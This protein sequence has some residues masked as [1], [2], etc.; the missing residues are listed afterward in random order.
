V[1]RAGLNSAII[2]GVLI[3]KRAMRAC[4]VVIVGMMVGAAL[5]SVGGAFASIATKAGGAT[6]TVWPTIA[7]D[8]AHTGRSQFNTSANPGAQKWKLGT[9][10]IVSSPAVGA[11]GTIY[12]GS[13]DFNLYAVAPDGSRK[14]AF[15]TTSAV[16]SPSIGNDGTIYVSDDANL[17][18]VTPNGTKKWAFPTRVGVPSL[19]A[20]RP[21]ASSTGG[22]VA[23]P[24]ISAEGTVYVTTGE[25]LYAV[26]PDGALNWKLAISY[27]ARSSPAIGPDGVIYVGSGDGNLYAINPDG[28]KRW[29]FET[30][31]FVDSSPAIGTDGTI[32]VATGYPDANLYAIRYNG[33]PKWAFKTGDGASFSPPALAADGTIYVGCYDG[34]L[35]A[36]DSNGKMKWAI[37]VGV[38]ENAAP[39]IGSDGT[40][41]VA[42]DD[43]HLYAIKPDGTQKWAFASGSDKHSSVAIGTDGT[44]Y[45]GSGDNNLYAVGGASSAG[46]DDRDHCEP[47]GGLADVP[48]R[49]SPRWP[50]HFGNEGQSRHFEVGIANRRQPGSNWLAGDSRRW[51]YLRFR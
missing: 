7:H 23:M 39:A 43:S 12:A 22:V 49:S 51:H 19:Q 37:A 30:G 50:E 11:D 10:G 6:S 38:I 16:G 15:T 31:S 36:I 32:Y 33:T 27:A 9:G 48:P 4:P 40:I 5:I 1:H 41:Y 13:S 34:R 26:N 20:R 46:C 25:Y 44:V 47:K 29:A 14:W 17:Y 2:W 28:T 24:A 8:R 45:L 42:S 18:A 3:S 35:Y 21:G